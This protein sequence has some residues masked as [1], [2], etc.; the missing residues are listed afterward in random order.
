[1][2]LFKT[3]MVFTVVVLTMIIVTP[4]GLV[5]LILRGIGLKR[6]MALGVYKIAQGWARLL[7]LCTGCKLTVLGRENIPRKEGVCFISNHG[8][9]FDIILH[10]AFIGR[11]F[12]FVAKKEL[13]LIPILNGWILLLGGLFIDRKNIRKAVAT[14]NAGVSRIE[15]GGA[16]I[17][18][19]EGTRSKGRGLLPFR[20]GALKLATQAG[21]PIV[22]VAIQ[23]SYDVFERTGR[24]KAVPVRIVFM[25]PIGPMDIPA[26]ER[27]SVLAEHVQ[28]IIAAALE[29]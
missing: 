18:F 25:P 29:S 4:L 23:G 1:M 17:I 10:L 20:P 12:G 28:G 8:S 22:P 15:K 5:A 3:A 26:G 2:E 27:R 14:I 11:P 7:I 19:P 21:A 24:V 9:I 6:L 16:M 13:A